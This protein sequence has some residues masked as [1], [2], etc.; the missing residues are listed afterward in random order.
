MFYLETRA[1]LIDTNELD[2]DNNDNQIEIGKKGFRRKNILDKLSEKY[3]GKAVSRKSL[4]SEYDLEASA[5]SLSPD[6][7]DNA[8]DVSS[9]EES[10][11]G[12]ETDDQSTSQANNSLDDDIS[13]VDSA[14]ED[15]MDEEIDSDEAE[16]DSVKIFKAPVQAS[17]WQKKNATRNQLKLWELTL[18]SRI[19]CQEMLTLSN[20]LPQHDIFSQYSDQVKG[21]L[22][23][24]DGVFESV[25]LKLL[26]LQRKLF[27]QNSMTK[28]IVNSESGSRKRKGAPLEEIDSYCQEQS[29]ALGGVRNK[30]LKLWFDKTRLTTSD[31]SASK[32][33]ESFERTPVTQIA[34][35]LTDKDRLL[36]RTQSK[37]SQYRSLGVEIAQS[38]KEEGEE[39]N[40]QTTSLE[41][42][43]EIFDDDD[44]YHQLLR[45][46][47][48]Q[49]SMGSVGSS[50]SLELSRL[51]LKIQGLRSKAR[52]SVDTK[53]SKGRKIRYGIHSKLQSFM[54]PNDQSTVSHESRND[55]FKSLFG[56][57]FENLPD[58]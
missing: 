54:A 21:S 13:D 4:T 22:V 36:K 11:K 25:L 48:E 56:I 32:S 16:G 34:D 26:E 8:Q 7:I 2:D 40:E 12:N 58:Q 14:N 57:F 1:K 23:A 41:L 5:E 33:F 43:S 49:K 38:A 44:F 37:R 24:T 46:L 17:Q 31:K 50:D 10:N 20:R 53:A 47:I 55:I 45:H 28:N 27:S 29:A 18:E 15:G 6:T 30:I 19:K 39:T 42:D 9:D 3:Q 52:K 51:N 35:V